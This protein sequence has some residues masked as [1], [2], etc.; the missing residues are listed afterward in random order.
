MN[1]SI[2]F[3]PKIDGQEQCTVNNLEYIIRAYDIE[4]TVIR[5]IIW[6]LLI[7]SLTIVIIPTFKWLILM[8]FMV[9][10]VGLQLDGVRLVR[11]GCLG[12]IL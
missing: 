6:H 4:F 2:A 9:E 7:S 11:Q 12:P 8:P 10:D 5:C 1:L 3:N